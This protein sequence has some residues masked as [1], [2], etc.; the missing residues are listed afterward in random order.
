MSSKSSAPPCSFV[1]LELVILYFTGLPLALLSGTA[2][3]NHGNTTLDN[4][5]EK[6]WHQMLGV[7]TGQLARRLMLQCA[8][9]FRRVSVFA[10]VF[11]QACM[12]HLDH[13]TTRY[14]KKFSLAAFRSKLPKPKGYVKQ[15]ILE[16]FKLRGV[17]CTF[18]HELG[19]G[20]SAYDSRRKRERV[21]I[22]GP[23]SKYAF[24]NKT[25]LTLKEVFQIKQFAKLI[26]DW[27]IAGAWSK[28]SIPRVSFEYL[29]VSLWTQ[30][31]I[32]ILDVSLLTKEEYS[33]EVS[34]NRVNNMTYIIANVAIK[35][36]G[37]CLEG[38]PE[39]LLNIVPACRTGIPF[40]HKLPKNKV[41]GL[42]ELK[43]NIWA[44]IEEAV[45]G[46]CD[47][48]CDACHALIPEWQRFGGE[49]PAFYD[50]N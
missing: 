36:S 13:D 7:I 11:S 49:K 1:D 4:H 35:L 48:N 37:G 41:E 12:F 22:Y 39:C 6:E 2:T 19:K 16:C 33:T 42:C 3:N 10:K 28:S 47:P 21:L 43:Y 26:T 17:M 31:G 8:R 20:K 24:P 38:C 45:N 30:L 40:N 34:S 9:C 29:T 5:W 14:V 44:W 23:M 32:C 25:H 27:W 46:D 15:I 18:C 50:G